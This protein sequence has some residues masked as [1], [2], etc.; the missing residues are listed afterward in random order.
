MSETLTILRLSRPLIL[1]IQRM[2]SGW[3]LRMLTAFCRRFANIAIAS[4][5][6]GSSDTELP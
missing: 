1:S 4:S 2:A 5:G 3:M 6:L